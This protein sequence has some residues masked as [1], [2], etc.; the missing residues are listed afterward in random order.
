MVFLNSSFYSIIAKSNVDF[1]RNI[2]LSEIWTSLTVNFFSLSPKILKPLVSNRYLCT[3][4]F[5]RLLPFF[6]IW[7]L[8]VSV[9]IIHRCGYFISRGG[10]LHFRPPL[11]ISGWI[12]KETEKKSS[13]LKKKKNFR[14]KTA[15]SHCE[16]VNVPKIY[17]IVRSFSRF[18][19]TIRI[20]STHCRARFPSLKRRIF[21]R[22]R[23]SER[24]REY[25][26]LPTTSIPLTFCKTRISKRINA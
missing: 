22:T 26:L 18:S 14:E 4:L 16:I 15:K 1:W 9:I 2:F 20:I 10:W 6:F 24:S 17:K 5:S 11:L 3:T 25:Y 8:C 19:K 13:R 21:N 7:L 12:I 23:I